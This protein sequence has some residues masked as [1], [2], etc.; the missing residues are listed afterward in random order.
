MNTNH[1]N[2]R[3]TDDVCDKVDRNRLSKYAKMGLAD[4]LV[5]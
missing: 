3:T 5:V 4:N 1:R 2:G